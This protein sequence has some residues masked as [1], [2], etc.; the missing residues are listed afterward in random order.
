M[1]TADCLLLLPDPNTVDLE[2]ALTALAEHH[3]TLGRIFWIRWHAQLL[4]DL[5]AQVCQLVP[6][7]VQRRAHDGLALVGLEGTGLR[8]YHN[9]LRGGDRAH[10]VHG[11]LLT[12]AR[13]QPHCLLRCTFHAALFI[14]T[15]IRY[16][17]VVSVVDQ[18]VRHEVLLVTAVCRREPGKDLRFGATGRRRAIDD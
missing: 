13:R 10:M 8:T 18:Y 15:V 9:G 6:L 16:R 5:L 11:V 12:V 17:V 4:V 1:V 14:N 3:A 2:R 7:G